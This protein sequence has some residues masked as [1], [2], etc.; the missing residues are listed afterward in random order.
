MTCSVVFGSRDE[1]WNPLSTY[2]HDDDDDVCY[3]DCHPKKR[4]IRVTDVS[5]VS[6]SLLS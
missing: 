1:K 3:N 6:V 4:G 5:R 2:G